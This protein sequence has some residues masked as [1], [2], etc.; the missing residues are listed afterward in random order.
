[1]K[2]GI[3]KNE[4]HYEVFVGGVYKGSSLNRIVALYAYEYFL[5]QYNKG[6]K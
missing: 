4:F 6:V 2:S 3:F 5:K 1:M